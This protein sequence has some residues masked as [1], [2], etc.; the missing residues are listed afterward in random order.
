VSQLASLSLTAFR[1]HASLRLELQ[2]GLVVLTGA[3]GAGKTNI[4][5]ALSLL[6]PG[7]G[8]RGAKLAEFQKFDSTVP[9]A[10][11]ACVDDTQLGT[12]RDPANPDAA[13]RIAVIDGQKASPQAFAEHLAI[14]WLT[15]AMDRLWTDSPSSRRR[16]LDRLTTALEPSHATHLSRY[17]DA[18]AER[19]RLLRD[20]VFDEIWLGG[21]ERTL[22]TEGMALAAHRR[23]LVKQLARYLPLSLEGVENWLD[24]LP[25]LLAEDRLRE[26]LAQSRRLDAAAGATTIGPHRTDLLAI[27]PDK[28]MPAALCSTGEQK[29]LLIR[30][31]LAHAECVRARRGSP[32]VLLLDE[33]CA[34]L[35]E[36][37]REDLFS[38]LQDMGAQAF[39]TG[40]DSSLFASLS[41]RFM[42][43]RLADGQVQK[44][45][46]LT[47]ALTSVSLDDTIV[48]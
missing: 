10:V 44:H 12:G 13:R 22:A 39:L 33:I 41:G 45:P 32:P 46:Q 36:T 30:L 7:R 28:N 17:E 34:H 35:D 11:S 4:L 31:V 48:T 18:L 24:T 38:T 14:S 29:L 37:R 20:G 3:N 2:P 21:I 16:F 25:A 15:P 23:E 42:C 8:L 9:W 6:A 27:H 40:A 47:S 19:N 43:Y 1:S 5:E 26:E